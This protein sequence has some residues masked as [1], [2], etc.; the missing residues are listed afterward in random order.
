MHSV[1]EEASQ[2]VVAEAPAVAAGYTLIKVT[3]NHVT[4]RQSQK[5]AK[6][7]NQRKKNERIR[8]ALK[9]LDQTK[10]SPQGLEQ[11]VRNMENQHH[12]QVDIAAIIDGLLLDHAPDLDL[13]LDPDPHVV[14]ETV[15]AVKKDILPVLRARGREKDDPAGIDDVLTADHPPAH[16]PDRHVATRNDI[17]QAHPD[18]EVLAIIHL[19]TIAVNATTNATATEIEG[20]GIETGT[21]TAIDT[22]NEIGIADEIVVGTEVV[23]AKSDRHRSNDQPINMTLLLSHIV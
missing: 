18:I 21:G 20:I 23:G 6:I 8:K 7:S 17:L 3:G 9:W 1:Q 12:R 5:A 2:A 15:I 4:N 16:D 13:D 11:I 14:T 19:A 22:A 10:T